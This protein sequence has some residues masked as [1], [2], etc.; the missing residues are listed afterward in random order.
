M[1]KSLVNLGFSFNK[2]DEN[3]I[4]VSSIHPVFLENKIQE[5][6]QELIDNEI[7][8]F[9]NNSNSLNDYIAK[10]LSKCSSIK[11]G[12]KLEKLQQESLVND[13]FAC[14]ESN[15]SPFDKIIFKIV[16]TDSIKKMFFK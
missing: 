4:E 3:Q 10:V 1:R 11:S 15:I 5:V 12:F 6:F 9:K 14:K 16:S 13:L 2:F 8:E 7:S